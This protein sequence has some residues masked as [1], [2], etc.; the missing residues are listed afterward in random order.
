[1][2]FLKNELPDSFKAVN[3]INQNIDGQPVMLEASG[4]SY[5]LY[6]HISATQLVYQLL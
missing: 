3:W 4:D 1:M 2:N 6:N 5:T